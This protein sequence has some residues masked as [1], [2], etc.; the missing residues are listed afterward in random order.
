MTA[1]VVN[2]AMG[3][4]LYACPTRSTGSLFQ[5]AVPHRLSLAFAGGSKFF[6]APVNERWRHR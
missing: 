2:D 6:R 4:A 3:R 5:Y 1:A